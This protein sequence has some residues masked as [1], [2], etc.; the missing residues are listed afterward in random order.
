M[1]DD[2][3]PAA[4]LTGFDPAYKLLPLT[5]QERL[6]WVERGLEALPVGEAEPW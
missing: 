5:L 3:A 6:A 1:L 2:I 4:D